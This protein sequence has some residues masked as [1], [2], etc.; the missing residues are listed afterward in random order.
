MEQQ[1]SA[2]LARVLALLGQPFRT[3]APSP[4]RSCG[5]PWTCF[6]ASRPGAGLG[7]LIH[8]PWACMLL[9]ET[10]LGVPGTQVTLASPGVLD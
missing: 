7:S 8:F 4:P 5:C 6:L 10:G 2:A 3:L 1:E 9:C